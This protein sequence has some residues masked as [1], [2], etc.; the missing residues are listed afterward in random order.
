MSD[1]MLD[2]FAGTKKV[3]RDRA[4]KE[5]SPLYTYR[6]GAIVA[7]ATDAREIATQFPAARAYQP[8]NFIEITNNDV[9]NLTLLINS[10]EQI[11]VPAGVIKTIKRPAIWL[12]AVRNDD[13]A[14][15]STVDAIIVNVMRE[16]MTSD[17]AVREAV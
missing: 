15:A 8:L 6:P 16:A 10:N 9:V 1:K 2:W 11:P 13:A 12:F 17:E 14:V 3:T 4:R 7:G 5:G